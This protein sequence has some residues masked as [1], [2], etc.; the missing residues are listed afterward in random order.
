M[1]P[2]A[3]VVVGQFFCCAILVG[4]AFNTLIGYAIGSWKGAP[5]AGA[6]LGLM[7]G[8]VGWLLVAV[9]IDDRATCS[10]CGGKV[11]VNARRCRHCGVRLYDDPPPRPRTSGRDDR[12]RRTRRRIAEDA[13]DEDSR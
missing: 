4:W 5:L 7:I 11:L 10:E 13:E 9:F 12:I 3:E 8:P 6:V 2:N 1:N